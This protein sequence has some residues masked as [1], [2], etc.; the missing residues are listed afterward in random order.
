MMVND[1]FDFEEICTENSFIS[2]IE[3]LESNKLLQKDIK[4]KLVL[5]KNILAVKCIIKENEIPYTWKVARCSDSVWEWL[6]ELSTFSLPIFSKAKILDFIWVYKKNNKFGE[7]SYELYEKALTHKVVITFEEEYFTL[8]RMM[9]IFSRLLSE[10]NKSTLK[11]MILQFLDKWKDDITAHTLFIMQTARK[12]NILEK[13]SLKSLCE[14][15]ISLLYTQ[16][17][18]TIVL[19]YFSIL[20]ELYKSDKENL[21]K[22]LKKEAEYNI[23]LSKKNSA[24]YLK[25]RCLKKAILLLKKVTGTEARRKSLL[26]DLKVIQK[27]NIEN[28]KMNTYDID[29][30][31]YHTEIEKLTEKMTEK[32]ILYFFVSYIPLLK[33]ATYNGTIN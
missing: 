30:T 32:E 31:K 25:E 1:F 12:L 7:Q 5:V 18:E 2:K 20:K 26:K 3:G 8:S 16:G 22:F 29:L 9:V 33:K 13:D 10:E 28:L 23:F 15:K 21:N 4:E 17:Y 14:T 6:I 27:Q 19:G 11:R 24:G